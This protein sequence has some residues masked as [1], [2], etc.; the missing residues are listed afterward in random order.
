[1]REKIIQIFS[2]ELSL[3]PSDITRDLQYNSIPEWDSVSHMTL[4]AAL[5]EKFG[6]MFQ[7][8]E[9]VEMTTISAIE[10]I[11]SKHVSL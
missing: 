1:M 9:I 6:V 4:I 5:E 7:S 11:V 8:E 10:R 3:A 2:E